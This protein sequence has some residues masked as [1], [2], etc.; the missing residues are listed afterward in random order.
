MTKQEKMREELAKRRYY[1]GWVSIG[2]NIPSW[3]DKT[4]VEREYFRGKIDEDF[5][6]L[7]DNGVVLKVDDLP[8]ITKKGWYV[9]VV[10]L[11]KEKE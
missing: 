8:I 2:G 10:P 7:H 3:E 1:D 11:I 9:R 4:E 5:K 6:Y